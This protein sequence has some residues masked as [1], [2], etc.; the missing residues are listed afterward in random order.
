M[1]F[2]LSIT[3]TMYGMKHAYE[4]KS[5]FETLF[6]DL[7]TYLSETYYIDEIFS[8]E[9]NGKYDEIPCH[10]DDLKDYNIDGDDM[11]LKYDPEN[12]TF[13]LWF[14]YEGGDI[15]ATINNVTDDLPK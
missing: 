4:F 5:S 1:L 7:M 15:Y 3:T 9:T 8:E 2:L 11:V 10:I 13:E 6:T 14:R 12:Q